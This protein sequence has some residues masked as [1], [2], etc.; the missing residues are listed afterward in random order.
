M[1]RYFIPHEYNQHRPQ[2]LRHP[3]LTGFLIFVLT[4]ELTFNLFFS[5]YPKLL[6]FATSIYY[7]ELIQLTNE[8]RRTKKIPEL[9]E[10]QVLSRAA[11]LK[12]KDMFAQDYWAHTA[13]SGTTPWHWFDET[14]YHYVIAGENLARDFN[15]S[16][17]VVAGWMASPSHRDNLLNENFTEFGIAVVNGKLLGE[18]TTLVVQ[19]FG[20]P[21][22]QLVTTE[23]AQ[24]P[25]V[26]QEVVEKEQVPVVQKEEV[27]EK[28]PIVSPEEVFF[29]SSPEPLV[30]SRNEKLYPVG[31]SAQQLSGLAKFKA[32]SFVVLDPRNWGMG[33]KFLIISLGILLAL[34]VVDSYIIWRNRIVRQN[35]HSLLHAGILGL[36]I[37][38]IIYSNFGLIL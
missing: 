14:G 21:T 13:P 16:R 24:I 37:I 6:G 32:V 4:I 18:E 9:K 15:T 7:N 10:N 17:G 35:S 5:T 30:I 22:P 11:E 34:F 38:G 19:F 26:V 2:I 36:L 1:K 25:P 29:S 3:G 31:V 28:S 27:A 23:V 20:R 33:Q 12:A 8:E